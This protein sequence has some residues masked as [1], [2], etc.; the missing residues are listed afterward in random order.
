MRRGEGEEGQGTP[1]WFDW[2]A[3]ILAILLLLALAGLVAAEEI[4]A[5][6]AGFAAGVVIVCLVIL[7]VS[8]SRFAQVESVKAFGVELTIA[9]ASM[10]SA[11]TA[12]LA[13][14]DETGKEGDVS[15]IVDL[16]F[17]LEAKLAYVAKHLLGFDG[18]GH[19]SPFLTLGSLRYDE[20]MSREDAIAARH[21]LGL[22]SAAVKAASDQDRR[23][24]LAKAKPFVRNIRATIFHD[25]V[26]T[27]L[28]KDFQL[29]VSRSDRGGGRR[30][31]FELRSNRPGRV[32]VFPAFA[33][34]GGYWKEE[35]VKQ[36]AADLAQDSD[37]ALIVVPP[38]AP[39]SDPGVDGVTV[40]RLDELVHAAAAG[41][42][43]DSVLAGGG[44]G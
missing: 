15:E 25:V 4:D 33:G 8:L 14:D 20:Y 2:G 5:G 10:A 31:D 34:G 42:P 35:R 16:Q 38:N 29:S 24:Y 40:A 41:Q 43:F 18:T 17:L 21:L 28:E 13:Y 22:Q 30:P 7:A 26:K 19:W 39:T 9:Q 36:R 11:P 3:R 32:L 37:R 12:N 1:P 44:S 6:R 23:A 27:V